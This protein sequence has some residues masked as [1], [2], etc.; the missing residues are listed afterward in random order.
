[1]PELPEVETLRLGLRRKLLG[2][3]ILLIKVLAPKIIS[4]NGTKRK[5]STS[6]TQKFL[7]GI[8]NKKISEIE[9]I[10]K[11][12]IFKFADES[13]LVIHLKMTGQLVFVGKNKE[14]VLGGHPI[15]ND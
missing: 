15:K 2:Q 11:N 7:F 10:A 3:K 13:V 5:A 14:R 12:L 4:G 8:K 9:R 6:K 1:M